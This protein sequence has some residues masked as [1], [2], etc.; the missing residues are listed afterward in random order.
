MR[1]RRSIVGCFSCALVAL[2]LLCHG[3]GAA[4]WY[5]LSDGQLVHDA[6]AP[7]L[8]PALT[9]DRTD[10]TGLDLSLRLAGVALGDVQRKA[11]RYTN[12]TLP[13]CATGWRGRR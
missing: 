5:A 4:D 3:A 10:G 8:E 13:G 12:A 6:A 7:P 9:V 2:L 1:R 11:D